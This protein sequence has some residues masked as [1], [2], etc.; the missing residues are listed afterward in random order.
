M[1]YYGEINT[2]PTSRFENPVEFGGEEKEGEEVQRF[3]VVG[4]G[5]GAFR[6]A[7]VGGEEAG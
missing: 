3:V 6:E 2:A 4:G 5:E 1:Y 7:E